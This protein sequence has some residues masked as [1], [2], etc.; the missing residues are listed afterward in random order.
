MSPISLAAANSLRRESESKLL[1]MKEA[2]DLQL[3]GSDNLRL[4]VGLVLDD[5][6][7]EA[8]AAPSQ[9]VSQLIKRV[10]GLKQ[11]A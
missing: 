3:D 11:V 9:L 5:L 6:G 10:D 2:L 7:V 8:A 4:A 1:E